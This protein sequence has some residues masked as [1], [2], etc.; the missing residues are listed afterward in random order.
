MQEVTFAV[1]TVDGT[2][3]FGSVPGR[4]VRRDGVLYQEGPWEAT[5]EAIEGRAQGWPAAR[6]APA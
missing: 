4:A 3:R 2:L 1:L 5:G 6:S